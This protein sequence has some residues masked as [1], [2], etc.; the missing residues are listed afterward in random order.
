[1]RSYDVII[2]GGGL[3]GASLALALTEKSFSVAVIETRNPALSKSATPQSDP[4]VTA[5][6][7]VSRRF[8]QALDLWPRLQNLCGHI[9][10]I[11]VSDANGAGVCSMHA[12]HIRAPALGYVIENFQLLQLLWQQMEHAGVAIH[13][14][15]NIDA[16][17]TRTDAVQVRLQDGRLLRSRLLIACDGAQSATRKRA[18]IS[19]HHYDYRQTAVLATVT[20]QNPLRG[21][22]YERFTGD[23][24]MAMLPM[25]SMDGTMRYALIWCMPT[26]QANLYMRY[27]EQRFA[28]QLRLR[29]GRRLGKLRL[30]G[31]RYRYPLHFSVAA[32]TIAP[33]CLLVGN[34]AH[35]LH[36][37]AGQGFNLSL[38][39][40]AR[41]RE[42]LVLTLA[43]GGDI[44]SASSLQ[45]IAVQYALDTEC[46]AMAT[47]YLVL[48][49]SNS[50]FGVTMLRNLGLLGFDHF[51][52]LKR[53]LTRQAMG[54]RQLPLLSRGVA[55]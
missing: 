50:L 30:Q 44:G 5:L 51:P 49:F 6:S 37:V 8:F 27:D 1:M 28:D 23:G 3:V 19:A 32:G 20:A 25:Q 46:T 24:P 13:A 17:D 34:A 54:G 33:R 4:R 55:V 40:I 52:M 36:P 16:I 43:A 18:G 7:D 15:A 9:E 10:H 14:P 42:Q 38:R 48:G 39:E 21:W 53:W 47:H 22:A 35:S 11:H 41:I 45:T 31:P 2:N 26:E 12:E 29:F